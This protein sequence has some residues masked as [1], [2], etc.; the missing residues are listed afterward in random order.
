MAIKK[1]TKVEL[2]TME[3]LINRA[4]QNG[5]PIP[6]TDPIKSDVTITVVPQDLPSSQ[7]DI[8]LD[9]RGAR[10]G[11]FTDHARLAQQLQDCM[12]NH[13]IDNEHG[14]VHQP[15]NNLTPVMK[16]ALT[17]DADKTARI[18]NGDPF[19]FDNW[20]DKQGYAK[21][22]EDRLPKTE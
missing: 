18:I 15:W 20:R 6:C 9:E 11:D 13:T 10:Y 7:V 5:Q 19:Y 2:I 16:Q 3:L 4:V 22:V 12:R 1:L 14:E 8:T 21:L 17:V